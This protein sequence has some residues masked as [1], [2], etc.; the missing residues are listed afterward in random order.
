MAIRHRADFSYQS[1]RG[2]S[3]GLLS[4][5]VPS[6]GRSFMVVDARGASNARLILG[7]FSHASNYAFRAPYPT[8]EQIRRTVIPRFIGICTSSGTIVT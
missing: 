4:Q 7:A 8:R 5:S 6:S 3:T 2:S 1:H